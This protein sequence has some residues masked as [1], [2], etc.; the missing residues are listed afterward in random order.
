[1]KACITKNNL[2]QILS[3]VILLFLWQIFA[4]VVQNEIKLPS[5]YDTYISL[6]DIVS[7]DNFLINI[8]GTIKRTF[9]S[10]FISFVL[11]IT[12]G[13]LSGFYDA[14]HYILKPIMLVLR[15]TPTFVII[16]LSLIWL[17]REISP[18]L[19]GFLVVFPL[20]YNA[21]E[22]SIKNVD[23][24][25]LEMTKMYCFSKKKK[26]K[27]LFIPTIKSSLLAIS[28]TTIGLNI[29]VCI[30]AEVLSQPKY[31]IG[32]GFQ[33]EKVA[34]N[35]AGVIAWTIIAILLSALCEYI[36]SKILRFCFK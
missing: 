35:T 4:M 21:V 31:A 13:M 25:L 24:K 14:V 27:Y 11:G 3:I 29:K 16:L 18:I 32:S 7:K 19:V 26:L 6:I 36:V 22:D 23:N 15:S 2:Y 17:G 5:P 33:M 12:L 34:L 9:I 28:A 20:I 10:F 30:A 1:M 8:M